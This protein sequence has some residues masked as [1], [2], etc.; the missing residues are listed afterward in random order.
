MVV[1]AVINLMIAMVPSVIVSAVRRNLATGVSGVCGLVGVN[2]LTQPATPAA[3][4][5]L[6]HIHFHA[7]HGSLLCW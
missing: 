1:M 2:E 6:H 3:A 5:V 4:R 7:G